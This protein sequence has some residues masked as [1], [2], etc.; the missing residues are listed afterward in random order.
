MNEKKIIII[1]Y[2][3]QCFLVNA[4]Q[5]SSANRYDHDHHICIPKG[6]APHTEGDQIPEDR[7]DYSLDATN[8]KTISGATEAP[9]STKAVEPI[10]HDGEEG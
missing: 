3:R 5:S 10:I 2:F 1:I 4:A 6:S 7:A 9:R 8:P